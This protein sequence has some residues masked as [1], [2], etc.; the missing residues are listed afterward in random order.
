VI[1]QKKKNVEQ[2]IEETAK[3]T[4]SA[5]LGQQRQQRSPN[6]YRAMERLLRNYPKLK[7]LVENVDDYGFVPGERSKSI[8]IAPPPGGMMRD[9]NEILEEIV[10]DRQVSYERTKARFEEIDSVVQQFADNPEF[11][12]IRMY[13]FNEDAFGNDRA[14]DSRPYT[15]EEI[16]EDL[17]GLVGAALQVLYPCQSIKKEGIIEINTFKKDNYAC[18]EISDNGAG[19]P[20]ENLNKI[21]DFGFT[22]KKI[23]QGTGLGLALAKKIIDE[24]KGKI[25]VESVLNKK[26]TFTIYLPIK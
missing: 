4:A 23:G 15:F 20:E 6:L 19:I 14:P 18:V 12:V 10:A 16:S 21:F 7:K 9:R 3:A 24:H 13:Y 22:T 1:Q 5:V 8:T 17:S 25:E 2:I 11:I 26:T